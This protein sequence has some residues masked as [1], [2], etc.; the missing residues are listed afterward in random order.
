MDRSNNQDKNYILKQA[1]ADSKETLVGDAVI[2]AL[3][4]FQLIH[5][6]LGLDDGLLIDLKN[7][8]NIDYIFLES[9]YFLLADIYRLLH[10]ENQRGISLGWSV[11]LRQVLDGVVSPIPGM[12]GSF[13]KKTSGLF[14][15]YY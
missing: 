7:Q 8:N 14:E 2:L 11:P 15:N 5:N 6:P 3:Q 13:W 12:A 9:S 10:S 4:N 1:Q